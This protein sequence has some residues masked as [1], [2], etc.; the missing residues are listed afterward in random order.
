MTSFSLDPCSLWRAP[1]QLLIAPGASFSGYRGFVNDPRQ[2]PIRIKAYMCATPKSLAHRPW[3]RYEAPEIRRFHTVSNLSLSQILWLLA[4]P[5]AARG[6]G[7]SNCQRQKTSIGRMQ[8]RPIKP[9]GFI[10][11]P[12]PVDRRIQAVCYFIL[13]QFSTPLS[14]R[15]LGFPIASGG[16][17]PT[18]IPVP[19]STQACKL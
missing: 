19:P 5:V 10:P 2:S 17:I 18:P 14:V 7:E 11:T 15:V 3:P 6:M 9:I 13:L 16:L 1:L 8:R 12:F 4:N